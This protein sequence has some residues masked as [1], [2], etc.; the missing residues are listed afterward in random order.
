MGSFGQ[1]DQ[2]SIEDLRDDL[3]TYQGQRFQLALEF[4]QSQLSGTDWAPIAGLG[5]QYSGVM[6]WTDDWNIYAKFDKAFH[7]NA[8]A[9]PHQRSLGR[10]ISQFTI[11]K[12]E[13]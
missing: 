2:N 13:I 4:I 10:T 3:S 12:K 6:V 1:S 9:S 5:G 11:V 7:A 8:W